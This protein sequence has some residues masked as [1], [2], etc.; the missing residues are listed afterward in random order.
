MLFLKLVSTKCCNTRL[1]S[2]GPKSD[3]NE[4]NHGQSTAIRQKDKKT[5]RPEKMHNS[6]IVMHS[7][8]VIKTYMCIS[9]FPTSGIAPTDFMT[10]P[11]T[12]TIDR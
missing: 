7:S 11:K 1:D 5:N 9:L 8:I 4:A 3:E 10:W 2:T 12:Y 6:H